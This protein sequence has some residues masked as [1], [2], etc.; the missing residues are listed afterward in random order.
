MLQAKVLYFGE[1]MLIIQF[2]Q[3]VPEKLYMIYL[4]MH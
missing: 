3:A 1:A 2:V 4:D